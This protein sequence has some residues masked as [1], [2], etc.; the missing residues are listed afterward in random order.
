MRE[1]GQINISFT[2]GAQQKLIASVYNS[3]TL[4]SVGKVSS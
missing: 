3:Q 4:K 1:K 2:T